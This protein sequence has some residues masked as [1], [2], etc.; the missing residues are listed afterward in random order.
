MRAIEQTWVRFGI[1]AL[2]GAAPALAQDR[3]AG[4]RD[5][6]RIRSGYNDQFTI[7]V[8]G[9][10][11][12]EIFRRLK[13][14]RPDRLYTYRGAIKHGKNVQCLVEQPERDRTPEYTCMIHLDESGQAAPVRNG[15]H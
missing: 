11:A 12:Q 4:P 10:A 8:H 1:I 15:I 14:V 9:P 2:L 5:S 7:T 3:A 6:V 13:Q